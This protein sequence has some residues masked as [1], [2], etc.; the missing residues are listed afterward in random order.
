MVFN[1]MDE[2]FQCG[3]PWGYSSCMVT[4]GLFDGVSREEKR[5]MRQAEQAA[6]RFRAERGYEHSYAFSR[7]LYWFAQ[8]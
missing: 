3:L 8:A 2:H 4:K 5:A 7:L 6:R 1:S